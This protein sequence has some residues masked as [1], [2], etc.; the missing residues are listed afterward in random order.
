MKPRALCP[1]RRRQQRPFS[2]MAQPPPPP[3]QSSTPLSPNRPE[4]LLP[5]LSP[6]GPACHGDGAPYVQRESPVGSSETET[7][8]F[9]DSESATNVFDKFKK[10]GT[11]TSSAGLSEHN[12]KAARGNMAS[13]VVTLF[14][15]SHSL[16]ATEL[17]HKRRSKQLCAGGMDY[18]LSDEY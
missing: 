3:S 12:F 10:H 5:E 4:R 13:F 18:F 2:A 1:H 14:D 11:A 7:G 17:R 15:A 6:L 8:F 16:T 9:T